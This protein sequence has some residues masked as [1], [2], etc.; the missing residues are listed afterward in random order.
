MSLTAVRNGLAARLNTINGLR[1]Y[2]T[3]PEIVPELP[4][5]VLRA[6]EPFAAY[7][8]VMGAADVRYSFEVLL[9]VSS[10]DEGQALADLEPYVSPTGNSSV[11]AAVD[12]DLGGN[13][14]YARVSGVPSVGRLT[15][16]RT[17]YWGASFRVEVYES[18]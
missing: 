5:A 10:G 9:L 15:Y 14:D 12:G 18:G 17:S 7:D 8:Q 11:K 4:A 6:R 13:A 3:P 1:V 16:H 2:Q